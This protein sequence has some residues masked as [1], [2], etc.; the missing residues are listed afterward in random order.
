MPNPKEKRAVEYF[1]NNNLPTA[2][3]DSLLVAGRGDK[4]HFVRFFASIPEGHAE[5]FRM[6]TTDHSLK[7]L[8]DTLCKHCNYYP[9]R[10]KSPAKNKVAAE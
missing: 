5:Q 7:E 4:M 8:I 6:M 9:T 10:K 2:F 1:A 3:V